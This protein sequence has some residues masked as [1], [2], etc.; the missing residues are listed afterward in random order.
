MWPLPSYKAFSVRTT[1]GAIELSFAKYLN[2]TYTPLFIENINLTSSNLIFKNCYSDYEINNSLNLTPSNIYYNGNFVSLNMI[3][4]SDCVSAK[5]GQIITTMPNTINHKSEFNETSVI[6]SISIVDSTIFYFG[7]IL[8]NFLN[9][10]DL[11]GS[12]IHAGQYPIQYDFSYINIMNCKCG[13]NYDESD[14]E[15]GRNNFLNIVNNTCT[16]YL[17]YFYANNH[18]ISNFIIKNNIY[19]QV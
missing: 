12:G 5:G 16:Q 18:I 9:Y 19:I 3:Y 1:Y 8:S 13:F 7:N 15:S 4:V 2:F 17:L 14:T 10:S 6:S 11:I